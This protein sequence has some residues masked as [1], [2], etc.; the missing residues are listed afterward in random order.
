MWQAVVFYNDRTEQPQRILT[1]IGDVMARVR[2]NRQYE[3]LIEL[4]TLIVARN[5]TLQ[6]HLWIAWKT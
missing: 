1:P 3:V 4:P 6:D 5:K 2:Q